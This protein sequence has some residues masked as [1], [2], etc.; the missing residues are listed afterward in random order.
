MTPG[1]D[2]E[3]LKTLEGAAE[4]NVNAKLLISLLEQP[5]DKYNRTVIENYISNLHKGTE[6]D[7]KQELAEELIKGDWYITADINGTEEKFQAVPVSILENL[8]NK[9]N[10]VCEYL[11]S[12][13]DDVLSA[14]L[15]ESTSNY[16]EDESS[17]AIEPYEESSDNAEV[18]SF[19]EFDD[20]MIS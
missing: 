5:N 17:V 7:L 11:D 8:I 1:L 4:M 19:V 12:G 6:Y 2:R 14:K 13:A 15:A 3:Y 18:P 20:S 9:I 16:F 10:S